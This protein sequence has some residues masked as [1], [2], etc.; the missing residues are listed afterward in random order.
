MHRRDRWTDGQ[1]DRQTNRHTDT[2]RQQRPRLRIASRGK[3]T[4]IYQLLLPFLTH[5]HNQSSCEW[6]EVSQVYPSLSLFLSAF[7]CFTL[8]PFC[9]HLGFSDACFLLYYGLFSNKNDWQEWLVS[10]VTYSVFMRMLTL[11][12]THSLSAHLY[13][14]E[15]VRCP[16]VLVEIMFIISPDSSL[17]IL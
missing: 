5:M 3:K 16:D 17:P 15:T 9:F 6:I 11:N 2:G 1:T 13:D 12:Y 10:A 7:V 8:G 14:V 4:I